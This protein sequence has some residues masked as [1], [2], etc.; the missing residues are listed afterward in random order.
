MKDSQFN[1][2]MAYLAIILSHVNTNVFMSIFW[3][4]VSAVYVILFIV[5]AIK[6][7]K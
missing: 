1:L 5:S 3:S 2:I 6:E 7:S 4:I